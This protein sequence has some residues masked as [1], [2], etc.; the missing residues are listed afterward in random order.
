MMTF[1]PF[2]ELCSARHN[3]PAELKSHRIQIDR[4]CSELD[5]RP[6]SAQLPTKFMVI[7]SNGFQKFHLSVAAAEAYKRGALSSYL[8]GA[9]PTPAVRGFLSLPFFRTSAK[10]K[11]LLARHDEIPESLVHAL[12]SAKAL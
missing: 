1:S 11:R 7:V 6:K 8:T 4:L 5:K 10:A 3:S 2:P 12:F 9:Y